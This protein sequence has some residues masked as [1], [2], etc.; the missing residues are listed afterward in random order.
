MGAALHKQQSAPTEKSMK[1][2]LLLVKQYFLRPNKC[3]SISTEQHC[4]A[5]P[6]SLNRDL[7][8][9]EEVDVI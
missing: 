7:L 3:L 8:Q 1:T 2:Q 6:V 5:R 4:A 9:L